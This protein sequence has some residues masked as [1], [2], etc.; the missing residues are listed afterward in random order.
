[1]RFRHYSEA[2]A[3]GENPVDILLL[4]AAGEIPEDPSPVAG[5]WI[6]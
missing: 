5:L 3:G 2:G 1:M 6:G 4:E